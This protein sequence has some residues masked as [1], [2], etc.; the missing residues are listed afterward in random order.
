LGRFDLDDIHIR[1]R[2]ATLLPNHQP[3]RLRPKRVPNCWNSE[4]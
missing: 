1:R 2:P 3:E 4:E